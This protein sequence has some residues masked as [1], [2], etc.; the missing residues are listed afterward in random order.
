MPRWLCLATDEAELA[1]G[2]LFAEIGRPGRDRMR[3]GFLS[4]ALR[5]L[6]SVVGVHA[7]AVGVVVVVASG[8]VVA[9][10]RT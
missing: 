1:G 9:S 8:F 6:M 10:G 2:G 4:C 7:H 5:P 3:L